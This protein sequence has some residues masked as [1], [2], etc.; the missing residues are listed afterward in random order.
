[1]KRQEAERNEETRG[2]AQIPRTQEAEEF[3][4]IHKAERNEKTKGFAQ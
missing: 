1:M 4:T 3:I 2:F